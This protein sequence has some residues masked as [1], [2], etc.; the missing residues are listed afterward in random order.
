MSECPP[1]ICMPPGSHVHLHVSRGYLHMM[2][3]MC[4]PSIE[5]LDDDMLE[6]SIYT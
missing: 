6:L 4:T 5:C 3:G 1:H 2:G